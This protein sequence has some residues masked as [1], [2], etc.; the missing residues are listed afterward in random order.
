MADTH[1]DDHGPGIW[2]EAC[3]SLGSILRVAALTLLLYGV[4]VGAVVYL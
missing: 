3:H 1:L 4:F 2:S